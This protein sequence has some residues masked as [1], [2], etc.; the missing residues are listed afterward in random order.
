MEKVYTEID[1]TYV[2]PKPRDLRSLKPDSCAV[3]I[4]KDKPCV[5][6]LKNL[7]GKEVENGNRHGYSCVWG[8]HDD[9]SD[10]YIVMNGEKKK[11]KFCDFCKD[12]LS[13]ITGNC[14]NRA[15]KPSGCSFQPADDLKPFE[16][17][18]TGWKKLRA[19]DLNE[20]TPFLKPYMGG[21]SFDPKLIKQNRKIRMIA[22]HL[23]EYQERKLEKYCS[24]CIF[25]GTCYLYSTKVAEHCMV[26]EEKTIKGCLVQIR[27]RFGNVDEYLGMLAYCGGKLTYKPEGQPQESEWRVSQPFSK[28]QYEIVGSYSG[29]SGSKA[30]RKLVEDSVTPVRVPTRNREKIAA[31]AWYYLDHYPF[32]RLWISL[33]QGGIEATHQVHGH[34]R[35]FRAEVFTSFNEIHYFFCR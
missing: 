1:G 3:R 29:Y 20:R 27:R 2:F 33:K 11:P 8:Y 17:N 13:G 30:P 9:K 15:V 5:I 28:K 19:I 26:T 18:L 14:L 6:P 16:I 32:H 35:F 10:P 21:V 12:R 7:Q 4:M 23:P 24:R 34:N 22:R 25:Q 31:L